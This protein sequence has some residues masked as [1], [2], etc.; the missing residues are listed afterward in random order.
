MGTPS[1][2][3]RSSLNA[4]NCWASFCWSIALYCH[5]LAACRT[6]VVRL[7]KSGNHSYQCSRKYCQIPMSVSVPRYSATISIAITSLSLKAGVNPFALTFWLTV[8]ALATFIKTNQNPNSERRRKA[9][10]L[11]IWVL[12]PNK[13][14]DSYI[15]LSISFILQNTA[16]IKCTIENIILIANGISLIF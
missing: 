9:P 7:F 5:G 6:K 2:R 13:N 10:P 8:I 14:G 11:T 16:M 4:P 1:I 15:T 3:C 12:C